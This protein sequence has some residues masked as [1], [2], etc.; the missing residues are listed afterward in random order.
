MRSP[1]NRGG[2]NAKT[3]RDKKYFGLVKLVLLY[4]EKCVAFKRHTSAKLAS[5]STR[6]LFYHSLS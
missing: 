5:L 3:L 4:T 6:I 1:L 2:L